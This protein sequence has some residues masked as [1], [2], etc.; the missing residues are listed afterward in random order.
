MIEK[1]NFGSNDPNRKNALNFG[2]IIWVV[3]IY[4]SRKGFKDSVESCR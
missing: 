4:N 1:Y 3:K 2:M